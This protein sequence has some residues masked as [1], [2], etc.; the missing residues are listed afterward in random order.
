MLVR[1]THKTYMSHFAIQERFHSFL[2]F[3]IG[4]LTLYIEI[5][6]Q[7]DLFFQRGRDGKLSSASRIALMFTT[8]KK[9]FPI[10]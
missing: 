3:R 2:Q 6:I 1:R 4:R 10:P 9:A 7:K 8:K 5:N